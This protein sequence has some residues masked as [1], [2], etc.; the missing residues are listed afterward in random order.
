MFTLLLSPAAK[1][2]TIGFDSGSLSE[3]EKINVIRVMSMKE[4]QLRLQ[5]TMFTME[6]FEVNFIILDF[7]HLLFNSPHPKKV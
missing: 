4:K 3:Q 7:L 1:Y 6:A 2:R 5:I